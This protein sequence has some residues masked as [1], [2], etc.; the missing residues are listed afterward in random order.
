MHKMVVLEN[1]LFCT[2]DTTNTFINSM[3]LISACIK[4]HPSWR[5]VWWGFSKRGD[6]QSRSLPRWWGDHCMW[7]MMRGGWKPMLS[8]I[9]LFFQRLRELIM[10]GPSPSDKKCNFIVSHTANV[11]LTIHPICTQSP[12]WQQEAWFDCSHPAIK[13][14]TNVWLTSPIHRLH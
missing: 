4:E 3:R 13:S 7:K 8:G 12:C 11:W 1:A 9:C 2:L 10:S 5:K 6:V 14:P